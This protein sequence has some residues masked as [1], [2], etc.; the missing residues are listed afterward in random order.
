MRTAQLCFLALTL[1]GFAQIFFNGV[2][3]GFP[4]LL[5]LGFT[6]V[7]GIELILKVFPKASAQDSRRGQHQYNAV[8]PEQSPQ[9]IVQP[10]PVP[11]VGV[12]GA[13]KPNAG[14]KREDQLSA[15]RSWTTERR[16]A[17]LAGLL[18]KGRITEE[19][20]RRRYKSLTQ[21]AKE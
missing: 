2:A 14:T 20:F 19:E 18:A 12:P 6:G 7:F 16:A 5:V 10:P 8:H 1:L 21:D 17:A 11:N 15:A 4:L 13:E 3:D 9:A